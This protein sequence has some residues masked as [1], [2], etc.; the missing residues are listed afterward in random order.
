MPRARPRMQSLRRRKAGVL[1]KKVEIE[2]EKAMPKGKAK[3]KLSLRVRRQMLRREM[4]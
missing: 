1:E 4:S 3:K 2:K